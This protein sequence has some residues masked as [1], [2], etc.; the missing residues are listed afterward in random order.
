MIR[1][2]ENGFS[3]RLWNYLKK[4]KEPGRLEYIRLQNAAKLFFLFFSC[5]FFSSPRWAENTRHFSVSFT[6]WCCSA[7]LKMPFPPFASVLHNHSKD[8]DDG[9]VTATWVVLYPRPFLSTVYE[10]RLSLFVQD[11]NITCWGIPS[12]V[13]MFNDLCLVLQLARWASEQMKICGAPHR[14]MHQTASL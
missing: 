8:T 14:L 4:R 6:A 2:Y 11:T 9:D 1:A 12:L 13:A 10:P 3:E 7:N 5:L